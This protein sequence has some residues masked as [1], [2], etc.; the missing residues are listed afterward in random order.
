MQAS[1][2]DRDRVPERV[3]VFRSGR[4]STTGI[5]VIYLKLLAAFVCSRYLR[6]ER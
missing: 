1:R 6:I 3:Y 2:I 4:E 5:R